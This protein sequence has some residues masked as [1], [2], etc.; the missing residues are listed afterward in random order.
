MQACEVL[1]KRVNMRLWLVLIAAVFVVFVLSSAGTA[2]ASDGGVGDEVL[3]PGEGGGRS[4]FTIEGYVN[5]M[6]FN[7]ISGVTVILRYVWPIYTTTD[8]RGYFR[9]QESFIEPNC[10]YEITVNGWKEY[11]GDYLFDPKY[12]QWYGRVKTDDVGYACVFIYMERSTI[13]NVPAAALFSNTKYAT[14]YYGTSQKS[15]FSHELSFSVAN[16]GIGTGYTTTISCEYIFGVEPLTKC[17][18][19]RWHYAATYYNDYEKR[20]VKTGIA[21]SEDYW[22]WGT[23]STEE[24]IDPNKLTSGYVDFPLARGTF[25]QATYREEG[26]YTWSARMGVPFAISYKA[27]GVTINL[28]VTVTSTGTNWVTY[29]VDRRGDTNPDTL[30]F[31][32]YT[33]GAFYDPNNQKGGIELHVWDMSGAG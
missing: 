3:T 7:S 9:F 4:Y 29:V 6:N 11:L 12:G 15:S 1:V 23:L 32:V 22:G 28:D 30:I 10:V 24:Y 5:D 13:V 33:G 20:I 16:Q 18:V 25:I 2:Y 21:G 17:Y 8:S 27:F 19:T 14:L 31:R 26:S